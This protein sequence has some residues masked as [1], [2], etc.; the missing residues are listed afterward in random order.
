[1]FPLKVASNRRAT[2]TSRVLR[3]AVGSHS[4]TYRAGQAAWLRVGAE[5]EQTP[6]SIASSPEETSRQGW[7]EFLVKTDQSSRFG[8]H[9]DELHRGSTV[10]VHGPIGAFVFPD[11]PIERRF[12][13][14]A[15]GTGIAP[16]RSMLR[17]AIDANVPGVKTLL[18]SARTPVEFAYLPELRALAREGTIGLALTLTGIADRWRHSRG[19]AGTELL[20]PLV[21]NETLCFLCGPPSMITEVPEILRS[22][23]VAPE[24]I[25]TE[26]S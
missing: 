18:Y 19:R 16:L 22:L 5:R 1:M 10:L 9:V 20:A 3:L 11:A 2:P 14:I 12:L 21:D 23:G 24:R 7:L 26:A 6:Y 13:F 4:F 17:H 25:R 15:G 8:A